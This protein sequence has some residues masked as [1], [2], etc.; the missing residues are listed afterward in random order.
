MALAKPLKT[1]IDRIG[2]VQAGTRVSSDAVFSDPFMRDHTRFDSFDEFCERSPWSLRRPERIRDVDRDRLDSYVAEMTDFETWEEMD[3]I[4]A[5]EE[6]IDQV[7][8]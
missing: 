8:W 1:A 6:I 7:V 2:D 3:R 4:A 5:E